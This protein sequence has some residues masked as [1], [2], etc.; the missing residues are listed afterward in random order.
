MNINESSLREYVNN[1]VNKL[2]EDIQTPKRAEQQRK[3]IKSAERS[4]IFGSWRNRADSIGR[5]RQLKRIDKREKED[6]KTT[7]GVSEPHH[8]RG[9]DESTPRRRRKRNVQEDVNLEEGKLKNALIAGAL[10][11]AMGAGAGVAT[12]HLSDFKSTI[13]DKVGQTVGIEKV[14]GTE[15]AKQGIRSQLGLGHNTPAGTRAAI[16]GAAGGALGV[17]SA[18]RRRKTNES[19]T[20][21][22]HNMDTQNFQNLQEI[23]KKLLGSYVAKAGEDLRRNKNKEFLRRGDAEYHASGGNR[24]TGPNPE[25]AAQARADAKTYSDKASRR[26]KGLAMAGKKIANESTLEEYVNNV[27]KSILED[28]QTPERAKQMKANISHAKKVKKSW[29]DAEKASWK[30]DRMD[31][32]EYVDGLLDAG[33]HLHKVKKRDAME[34]KSPK[35]Y[36]KGGKVVKEDVFDSNQSS[37]ASRANIKKAKKTLGA[38]SPHTKELAK[39]H[40]KMKNSRFVYGIADSEL[41]RRIADPEFQGSKPTLTPM[42]GKAWSGYDAIGGTSDRS[43]N[44]GIIKKVAAA[45][46]KN[47]GR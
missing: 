15:R 6:T 2:I 12:P 41:D 27:V 10:G 7:W 37:A 17:A 43:V 33:E 16:A 18:F 5:L 28:L 20:K 32:G 44:T 35:L 30:G 31:Y 4:A 14:G 13:Q 36:G 19:T 39:L 29:A 38:S 22:N 40:T 25:L 21:R 8:I 3:R 26:A 1:V 42:K 47:K 11:A 9:H 23:S 24:H 46:K 34:K 45:I